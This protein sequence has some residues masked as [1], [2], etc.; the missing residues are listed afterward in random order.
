M[1]QIWPLL[2]MQTFFSDSACHSLML[3]I[4]SITSP[5]TQ[6]IDD[7]RIDC[8]VSSIY[9]LSC[10]LFPLRRKNTHVGPQTFSLQQVMNIMQDYFFTLN[11]FEQTLNCISMVFDQGPLRPIHCS[12]HQPEYTNRGQACTA[13]KMLFTRTFDKVVLHYLF[14]GRVVYGF[15]TAG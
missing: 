6:K 9:R 7:L 8:Q 11:E 1:I 15:A 10:D 5:V 13:Q 2:E 14:G 12:L 4:L 3:I